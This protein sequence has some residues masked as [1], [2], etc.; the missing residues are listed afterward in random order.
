MG[1]KGEE[2][3]RPGQAACPP[4]LFPFPLSFSN[5]ARGGSPTPGGSRTPPGAPLGGRPHL[6]P[7]SFIYG[8]KGAPHDTQVNLRDHSL[9]VCGAPFH[10]IP[11][12]SYR[13]GA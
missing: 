9:A 3:G 7:P 12:R 1:H 8:G 10:H 6:T 4:F 13:S 2:E 11:P 5:K